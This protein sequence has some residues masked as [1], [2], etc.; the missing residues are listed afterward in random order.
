MVYGLLESPLLATD[1]KSLCELGSLL[2]DEII[3]VDNFEFNDAEAT[4]IMPFR[5]QFH[6][7]KEVALKSE[8]DWIVYEKDWM[9]SIVLV[10]NVTDWRKIDDQ[11]IG[12][13]TFNRFNYVQSRLI[14]SCCE[15]LVI[16]IDVSNIEVIMK[17]LG[18]SGKARIK[19]RKSGAEISS[20]TVY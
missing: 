13:Y 9:R 3:Q 20:N 5:R 6:G 18:F 8:D 19:R 7:G 1:P 4:L 15:L 17:D 14:I 2:H 12:D 11:E 16:E 10:K